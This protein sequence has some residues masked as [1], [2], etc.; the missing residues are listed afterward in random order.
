MAISQCRIRG[1]ICTTCWGAEVSENV[2]STGHGEPVEVLTKFRG[3]HLI[4]VAS[5]KWKI[6]EGSDLLYKGT[7]HHTQRESQPVVNGPSDRAT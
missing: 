4:H 6:Q 7:T 3:V 1:S 5:G 2:L